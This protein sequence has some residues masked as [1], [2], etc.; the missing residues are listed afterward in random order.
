MTK[1]EIITSDPEI[2][3]S[4]TDEQMGLVKALKSKFGIDKSMGAE[5]AS[6]SSAAKGIEAMIESLFNDNSR[7][8]RVANELIYSVS[9]GTSARVRGPERLDQLTKLLVDDLKRMRVELNQEKKLGLGDIHEEFVKAG[10]L[11]KYMKH[12][13][14]AAS[15]WAKDY[16]EEQWMEYSREIRQRENDVS[17]MDIDAPERFGVQYVPSKYGVHNDRL[18]EYSFRGILDHLRMLRDEA[19][20]TQEATGSVRLWKFFDEAGQ[21]LIN[22]VRK[23]KLATEL[24]ND[25]KIDLNKQNGHLLREI[26]RYLLEISDGGGNGKINILIEKGIIKIP[27]I[28]IESNH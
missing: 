26:G 9:T 1:L 21:E 4:L 3:K 15:A 25:V 16:T 18:R 27:T 7:F 13:E 10:N 20:A 14:I 6:Y 19:A 28:Y 8:R 11:E 23:E 12:L 24:N 5:A 22:E 2:I 17:S